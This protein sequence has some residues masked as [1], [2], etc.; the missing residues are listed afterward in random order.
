M[1]ATSQTTEAG[2]Q[3]GPPLNGKTLGMFG[4]TKINDTHLTELIVRKHCFHIKREKKW[5]V[6]PL[7]RMMVEDI[8][9][10]MKS[11]Q[12]SCHCARTGAGRSRSAAVSRKAP[13]EKPSALHPAP[14]LH[15]GDLEE[16]SSRLWVSVSSSRMSEC[17]PS[18]K[19]M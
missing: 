19:A 4:I 15:L 9:T 13:K 1:P 14:A 6:T 3:T 18:S 5:S 10:R 17:P 8:H 2:P 7:P 16:M 11:Q 12:G